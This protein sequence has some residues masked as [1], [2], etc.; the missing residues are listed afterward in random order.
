MSINDE[1]SPTVE[2]TRNVAVLS[3]YL[4]VSNSQKMQK[5]RKI[6]D[7]LKIEIF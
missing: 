7:R 6:Y 5:S 1:K 3:K 4:E 2:K